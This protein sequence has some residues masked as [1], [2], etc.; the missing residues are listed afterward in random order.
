MERC[1]HAV[2]SRSGHCQIVRSLSAMVPSVRI[3]NKCSRAA[4]R[5]TINFKSGSMVHRTQRHSVGD[6]NRCRY[7]VEHESESANTDCSLG[8]EMVEIRFSYL[9]RYDHCHVTYCHAHDGVMRVSSWRA[10]RR[11]KSRLVASSIHIEVARA[12]CRKN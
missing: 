8:R 11:R 6:R 5:V 12:V 9:W 1:S 7:L 4:H 2:Q 10:D 3:T